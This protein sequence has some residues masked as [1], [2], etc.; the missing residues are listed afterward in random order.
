MRVAIY[1]YTLYVLH[2]KNKSTYLLGILEKDSL[3]IFSRLS[4]DSEWNRNIP[5]KLKIVHIV[6]HKKKTGSNSYY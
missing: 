2:F 1:M 6:M 3:I 5:Q 4:R